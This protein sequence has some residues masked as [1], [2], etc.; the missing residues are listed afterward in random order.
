MS[1]NLMVR[2]CNHEPLGRHFR[3]TKIHK[4]GSVA[5]L[6][7]HGDTGILGIIMGVRDT[8][9]DHYNDPAEWMV[10]GIQILDEVQR[11]IEEPIHDDK[12]DFCPGGIPGG[13]QLGSVNDIFRSKMTRDEICGC[14][15]LKKP[16]LRTPKSPAESLDI[17]SHARCKFNCIDV[18]YFRK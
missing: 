16:L 6:K 9:W 7:C 13:V 18:D 5:K 10:F 11:S 12:R 8:G 1:R 15:V 4:V 3:R 17:E 2:V 14:I